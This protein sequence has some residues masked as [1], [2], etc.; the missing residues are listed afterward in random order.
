MA[1]YAAGTG[2]KRL[3]SSSAIFA[4]TT[5]G[6]HILRIH[7]YAGTKGTPT[8]QYIKSHPFTIGGHC[9]TIRY[10]PNGYGSQSLDHISFFLELGESIAKAMKA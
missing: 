9:W 1:T 6:Y 3:G 7:G 2:G 4:A 10:Y 8:R 5:S